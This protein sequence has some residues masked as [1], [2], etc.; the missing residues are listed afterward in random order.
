MKEINIVDKERF[1]E[2]DEKTVQL[3]WTDIE[4]RRYRLN[5]PVLEPDATPE[6]A[7]GKYERLN[8]DDEL[9]PLENAEKEIYEKNQ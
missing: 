5:A 8:E 3:R 2:V 9:P 4:I 6:P 7:S 1:Y